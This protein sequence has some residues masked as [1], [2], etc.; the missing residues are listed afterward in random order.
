M[1]R[2]SQG[3]DDALLRS[4]LAL[5]PTLG[6]SGL[7]VRKV[8]E[9]AGV[10]PAMFHYHFGSKAAFLRTLLGQLY[11]GMYSRLAAGAATGGPVLLR[12]EHALVALAGFVQAQRGLLGRLAVDAANGDAVVREFIRTNAPRHLGLLLQLLAEAE[13]QGLLRPA[14]PLQRFTFLM[15]AVVAPLLAVPA[16]MALGVAPALLGP[17]AAGQVTGD[18]AIRE[19][20]RWALGA[21]AADPPAAT[22]PPRK[23]SPR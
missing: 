17:E 11:E 2:P 4:G 18:A 16:V 3:I 22:T 20:V 9:H 1:A 7:S 15:G 21:L 19:R 14:P 12:L 23:R 8:A 13:S 10:N 5:L 6:C